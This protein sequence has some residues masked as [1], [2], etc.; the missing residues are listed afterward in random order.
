MRFMSSA[1]QT[2]ESS[3]AAQPVPKPS[4]SWGRIHHQLA[5]S[6]GISRNYIP[7]IE[8]MLGRLGKLYQPM[9]TRLRIRRLIEI[10]LTDP[11]SGP[12]PRS[13]ASP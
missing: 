1:H 5:H 11:V 4:A 9:A 6:V 10:A 8:A 12:G 7:E 3:A 13:I 2:H